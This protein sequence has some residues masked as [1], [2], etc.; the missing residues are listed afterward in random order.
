VIS[1]GVRT[2]FR[3]FIVPPAF[4]PPPHFVRPPLGFKKSLGGAESRWDYWEEQSVGA[5]APTL[6]PPASFAPP[7]CSKKR[8][9]AGGDSPPSKATPG[10]ECSPAGGDSRCD[11]RRPASP[12]PAKSLPFGSATKWG[13]IAPPIFFDFVGGGYRP[14]RSCR[15]LAAE[16]AAKHRVFSSSPTSLHSLSGMTSGGVG[17]TIGG[18]YR[19]PTLFK[20]KERS[21]SL[22]GVQRSGGR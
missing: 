3:S 8:S 18:G 7:L 15:C 6:S 11:L 10:R 19:P 9:P 2:P 22:S 17:G 4:G 12:P 13:A 21:H 20:K 1:G 14:P 16:L 5:S